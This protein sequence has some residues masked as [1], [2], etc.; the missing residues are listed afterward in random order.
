MSPKAIVEGRADDS[1]ETHRAAVTT[2][3]QK[4]CFS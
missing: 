4:R 2:V 3:V 1:E